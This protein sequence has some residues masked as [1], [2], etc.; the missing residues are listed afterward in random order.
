M[1]CVTPVNMVV[2]IQLQIIHKLWLTTTESN[3]MIF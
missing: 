3:R 1:G 2:T